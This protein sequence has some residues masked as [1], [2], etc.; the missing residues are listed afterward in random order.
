MNYLNIYNSII[1][2]RKENQLTNLNYSEKH[3]IL[4]RSLGG[5]DDETNIVRLTARE[6]YICHFLLLKMQQPG[7]SNFYKMLKAFVLMTWCSSNN[8]ARYVNSRLYEKY[9]SAFS[10]MQSDNQAGENNSQFGTRWI[11]NPVTGESKKTTNSIPVGWVAGRNKK[12]IKKGI[13]KC[14]QNDLYLHR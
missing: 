4:P 1:C 2:R 5:T 14:V 11:S 13:D 8:Q 3:H 9:R 7:S 12:N 6:H 10:K